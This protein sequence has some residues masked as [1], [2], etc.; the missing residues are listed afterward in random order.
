MANEVSR[1]T[2]RR[3]NS[4]TV[5]FR[6][7]TDGIEER[8][9]YPDVPG[10]TNESKA[11]GKFVTLL[12]HIENLG[13]ESDFLQPPRL[14]DRQGRLFDTV[15]SYCAEVSAAEFHNRRVDSATLQP[16]F[17]E[18]VVMVFDIVPDAQPVSVVPR[19]H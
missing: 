14:K 19:T 6:V 10:C 1:R 8:D 4:C 2:I 16:G 7:R 17:S 11:K 13:N 12:V 15:A 3:R 9:Q 18:D 5:R